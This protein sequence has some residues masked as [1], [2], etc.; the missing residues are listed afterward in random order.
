MHMHV[1]MRV[2]HKQVCAGKLTHVCRCGG[3]RNI[4]CVF[5]NPLSL[6]FLIQPLIDPGDDH[7]G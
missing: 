6:F 5:P 3:Q 7:F 4:S 2:W 1:C